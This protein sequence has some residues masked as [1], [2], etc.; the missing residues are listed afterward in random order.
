MSTTLFQYGSACNVM[1]SAAELSKL[2]DR[3]GKA[4]AESRIEKFSLQKAAKGYK[5]KSDYFAI[6]K[7]AHKDG[8]LSRVEDSLTIEEQAACIQASQQRAFVEWQMEKR[9]HKHRLQCGE[10]YNA[11]PYRAEAEPQVS[12]LWEIVGKLKETS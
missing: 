5:Y 9:T 4:G 7:W 6:L 8:D 1:L 3:F 2:R 10:P 12:D 11:C